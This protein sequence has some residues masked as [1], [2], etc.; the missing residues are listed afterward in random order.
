MKAMH[1]AVERQCW[2]MS[3]ALLVVTMA[4]KRRDS[5]SVSETRVVVEGSFHWSCFLSPTSKQRI[6]EAQL[7]HLGL[8]PGLHLKQRAVEG[9]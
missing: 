7:L 5:F 2:E 6:V 4:V 9:F 8:T 1:T 3:P